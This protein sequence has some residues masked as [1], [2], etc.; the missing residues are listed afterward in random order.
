MTGPRFA[1][2]VVHANLK[3]KSEYFGN[4]A[5]TSI[6]IVCREKHFKVTEDNIMYVI[7]INGSPRKDFNTAILLGHALRG[8]KSVGAITE[9]IHLYDFLYSGCM[10]CF[11]CKHKQNAG[12]GH[13]AVQDELSPVLE[14]IMACD[15]LL[16][17]SPIYFSDV[18]GM[19][20]AFM[21]RLLFMNLTY[22]D[23][24]RSAPGKHI[25]SA[26]FFTMN[27]PK[28]G[29]Q[30]YTPL[31]EQNSKCFNLLGGSTEYL[32]SFDTYQF[33]DYTK[34]AAGIFSVENKK[35][36]REKQWPLDCQ[37]AFEI[38]ARLAL[39]Q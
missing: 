25:S 17:G 39:N 21:E 30:Y 32:A 19:M 29:E 20:R 2:D 5:S 8:A 36:V 12:S 3:S 33:D 13:C 14:K 38:G 1:T 27:L 22:N 11:A 4:K 28:E 6:F 16:L 24:Y 23:P 26:F 18:T 7:A 35:Q 9:M 15:V 37:K 31:F 10:S 34:Y